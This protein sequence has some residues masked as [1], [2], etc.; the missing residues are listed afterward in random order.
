[1]KHL[2]AALRISVVVA[3]ILCAASPSAASA[4]GFVAF[5]AGQGD[6]GDQF[7]F[8]VTNL[9]GGFALFPEFQILDPIA[10]TDWS[11][12]LD[13]GTVLADS[14]SEYAA[15]S[16]LGSID[17]GAFLSASGLPFANL[18]FPSTTAFSSLTFSALLSE[19]IF[20][21]M[22]DVGAITTYVVSSAVITTKLLAAPGSVLIG[23]E[24]ALLDVDVTTAPVAV[25]E[26][27]TWTL[28]A[29]ALA[30]AIWRRRHATIGV[31]R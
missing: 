7:A 12:T 28:V 5:D 22:D 24:T 26:P 25:P 21:A 18:L 20:H 15:G 9:S 11:L 3:A 4:I 13:D 30:F 31:A 27:A 17:P 16:P 19:T 8:N 6:T 10:F 2:H 23:G 1:M 29:P 14:T